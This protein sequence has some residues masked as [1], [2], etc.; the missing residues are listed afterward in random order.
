[1]H[2]PHPGAPRL[3]DKLLSAR[4]F[5]SGM[6][7]VVISRVSLVI[8]LIAKCVRDGAKTPEKKLL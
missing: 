2:L 4:V 3:V 5:Q 7:L 1:M 6:F 8:V